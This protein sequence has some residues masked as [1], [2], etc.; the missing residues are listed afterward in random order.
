MSLN[1]LKQLIESGAS[2]FASG[3]RQLAEPDPNIPGSSIYDV[4][5]PPIAPGT[6]KTGQQWLKYFEKNHPDLNR[7]LSLTGLS[8]RLESLPQGSS[9]SFDEILALSKRADDD[10]EPWA[11]PVVDF[12]SGGGVGPFTARLQS[13]DPT[14][15]GPTMDALNKWY[16]EAEGLSPGDIYG[17][18]T[19]LAN[20]LD[21]LPP[22]ADQK[23]WPQ[24][25]ASPTGSLEP[26]PGWYG[27]TQGLNL[28]PGTMDL[29]EPG[30]PGRITGYRS[31][32]LGSD[33]LPDPHLGNDHYSHVQGESNFMRQLQ[34]WPLLD[35]GPVTN[36]RDRAS[37]I[38]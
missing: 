26:N 5:F 4:R 13:T 23:Y 31:A 38:A 28:Y 29:T 35:P 3:L 25:T 10:Y 27:E 32:L 21:E 2:R 15:S 9:V 12:G 24:S 8:G 22:I 7:E 1:L 11:Y 16:S 37:S 6:K 34:P 17:S 18:K 20:L 30:G 14:V 33:A 19:A 36:P